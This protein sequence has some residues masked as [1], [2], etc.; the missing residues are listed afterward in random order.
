MSVR[1]QFELQRG[2]FTLDLDF[3]ARSDGV[4]SLFGP[5]GSGK[6][7]VLRCIAGLERPHRAYLSVGGAVWHD[8]RK[9]LFL[10]PHRRQL[11]YVF[12]EAAL[13]SH[14]NVEQNLVYGFNRVSPAARHVTLDPVVA[15]LKLDPLLSRNV[16]TLSGGE[17]QRV[18]IARS[19]LTSPQLLLLDEPFSALDTPVRTQLRRD[20][21][22]LQ[23][24]LNLPT[25]LVTHDLAEAYFMSRRMAVLDHGRLLQMGTPETLMYHPRNH[26]VAHLTGCQNFF[27]GRVVRSNPKGL[28]VQSGQVNLLVPPNALTPGKTVELAVRGERIMLVRKD[29]PK[30]ARQ[31]ELSGAIVKV[32]TDGLNHTLYFRLDDG[33]RL[34]QGA[35]Y[36][37]E[38]TLP[39]Y[40]YERLRLELGQRWK[41]SIRP[42]AITLLY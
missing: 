6:T 18:A 31:N 19:L 5:S 40:V 20:V 35:A 28:W 30:D 26:T 17:Q 13:F 3:E 33:Q 4:T 8:T 1:I 38:V 10:P 2:S 11:G 41:I 37:L 22:A 42:E 23:K 36:D 32:T 14:L 15:M 34:R 16:W 21:A 29:L 27:T 7:T 24:E 9:G 12:Q 39:A 25:L